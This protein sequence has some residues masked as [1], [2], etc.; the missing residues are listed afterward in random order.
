MHVFSNGFIQVALVAL[1]W[2]DFGGF[3]VNFEHIL[4]LCYS[5][6]IVNF[7]QVNACWVTF[8]SRKIFYPENF[9]VFFL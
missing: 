1:L 8:H 5:V 3:I 4:H 2:C 7:E 9:K 6:S